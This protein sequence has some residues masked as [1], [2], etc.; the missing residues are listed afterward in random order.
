MNPPL[1]QDPVIADFLHG[2]QTVRS[3]IRR[4]IMF[5]SRARGDHKLDSDYDILIVVEKKDGS[6]RDI[7]YEAVMDVLLAHGRLVSLKIYED[8]EFLRLQ[9]LQTPFMKHVTEDGIVLG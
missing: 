5:G 7:L 1:S 3:R 8:C 6:L 2:I 4:M 9:A